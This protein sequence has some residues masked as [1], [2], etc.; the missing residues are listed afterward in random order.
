MNSTRTRDK[1][2]KGSVVDDPRTRRR[3]LSIRGRRKRNSFASFEFFFSKEKDRERSNEYLDAEE[4]FFI[5]RVYIAL[6]FESINLYNMN[7][8]DRAKI[9]YFA[10]SIPFLRLPPFLLFHGF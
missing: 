7:D 10:D 1:K 8:Q 9:E 2:K 3:F 6:V 5:L 4:R